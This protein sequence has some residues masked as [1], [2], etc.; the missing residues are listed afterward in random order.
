MR[1]LQGMKYMLAMFGWTFVVSGFCWFLGLIKSGF[2]DPNNA[3]LAIPA[4][5]FVL[6]GAVFVL[7]SVVAGH[8]DLR[9]SGDQAQLSPA[10]SP[11]P[12]V[13]LA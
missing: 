3:V 8:A 2:D 9:L 7:A 6:V 11:H 13:P 1:Y 10:I 5:M 12:H 4:A